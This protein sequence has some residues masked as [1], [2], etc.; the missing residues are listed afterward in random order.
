MLRACTAASTSATAWRSPSCYEIPA[1]SHPLGNQ[2]L[3]VERCEVEF[4]C[5]FVYFGKQSSR[6]LSCR[7]ASANDR[8]EIIRKPPTHGQNF[9]TMLTWAHQMR[10]LSLKRSTLRL[11]VPPK[12]ELALR[13][14]RELRRILSSQLCLSST[15]LLLQITG[16]PLLLAFNIFLR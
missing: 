3:S 9:A 12:A 7:Y 2:L 1:T 6:M 8:I 13:I 15:E 11:V 10:A 5:A 14:K 16:V 4:L